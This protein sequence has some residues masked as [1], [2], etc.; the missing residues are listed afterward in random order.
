MLTV[1]SATPCPP[2]RPGVPSTPLAPLRP[3]VSPH[4]AV[5]RGGKWER[6]CGEQEAASGSPTPCQCL[7][8]GDGGAAGAG[9]TKPC[10]APLRGL[11]WVA[12]A[13]SILPGEELNTSMLECP[14]EVSHPAAPGT[15]LAEVLVGGCHFPT[16]VP[17]GSFLAALWTQAARGR[18][19]QALVGFAVPAPVTMPSAWLRFHR[20]SILPSPVAV[21]AADR[22]CGCSGGAVAPCRGGGAQGVPRYTSV[23]PEMASRCASPIAAWCM[24]TR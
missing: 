6:A 1:P 22:P 13:V 15:V 19:Q 9:S 11:P 5:L 12:Q 21:P 10:T 7:R 18:S 16:Q 20:L 3:P 14:V 24:A 17:Y 8:A 2:P 23:C 4:A